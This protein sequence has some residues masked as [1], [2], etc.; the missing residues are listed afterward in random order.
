MSRFVTWVSV[1]VSMCAAGLAQGPSAPA[2]SPFKE[3]AFRSIGPDITTGRISDIEIDPK[4]PNVWYVAARVG[5]P[6]QD[7]EPRQH[8]D[9]DF[10]RRT[11]R[12]RSARCRSI[13]RTRTSSGSARARTTTSAASLRRRRLQVD[14]RRQD[15]EA[16]GAR[17]LRA[18]P[19]HRHR[20]AQLERRLRDARSGRCGAPGGD[21]G[22]YKTTDGGAD[23]EGGADGQRRHR[24][25]RHGHGSEEAGHDLCRRATAAARR[26][27]S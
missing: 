27:D 12:T 9:A 6:V 2:A 24:R 10:R 21:R 3:M 5:R 23:V 25:H 4:N 13:R 15:L 11:A 18:H 22:L 8:L 17:E 14:R 7:R 20:P 19:E 1:I 16:H 26:S